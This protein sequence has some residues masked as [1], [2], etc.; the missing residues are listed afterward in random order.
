MLTTC[1]CAAIL[2]CGLFPN[3]F[4]EGIGKYSKGVAKLHL[5]EN[6]K[7]RFLKARPLPFA[8]KTK[9]ELELERLQKLQIL[10]PV[11]HSEWATPIV[12]VL[13][14]DGGVR[15]C[16]NYKLTLNPCQDVDRF[17]VPHVDELFA[18]LSG[19]IYFAKLDLS[20]AYQQVELDAESQKLCITT[21]HKGL[22]NYTRVPYGTAS[23]P[24][25][26]AKIIEQVVQG[27]EGVI[28]HFDDI[29]IAGANIDQHRKS[30]SFPAKVTRGFAL[31]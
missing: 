4:E 13:K 16:G 20:Q 2:K 17:P 26:F 27:L 12:P 22:F 28:V 5:K 7:P 10:V 9:V 3:V 14:R 6:A 18:S 21:T 11:T 19:G 23:S 30:C 29:L 24:A 31:S 8:M 25:L 15:L 1:D